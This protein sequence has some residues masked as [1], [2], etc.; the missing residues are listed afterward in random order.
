LQKDTHK[1]AH[2]SVIDQV[3]S[4]EPCPAQPSRVAQARKGSAPAARTPL[5]HRAEHCHF[6]LPFDH[7]VKVPRMEGSSPTFTM[8]FLH[9][10]VSAILQLELLLDGSV[11]LDP[12][13]KAAA[14]CG[15]LPPLQAEFDNSILRLGNEDLQSPRSQQLYNAHVLLP[16]K[17][18]SGD[19]A[20][21]TP[22]RHLFSPRPKVYTFVNGEEALTHFH[23]TGRYVHP[24]TCRMPPG[25]HWYTQEVYMHSADSR[26]DISL[27]PFCP[28]P[29]LCKTLEGTT[30][31]STQKH[32]TDPSLDNHQAGLF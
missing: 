24:T 32:T 4:Q 12:P 11:P 10:S 31:L 26:H 30:D 7:Y 25:Y 1:A 27:D 13:S 9:H 5:L 21:P 3:I 20:E 16:G 14:A 19:T 2:L 17:H 6:V 29:I 18:M 15:C 22:A 8:G 28:L 23:D